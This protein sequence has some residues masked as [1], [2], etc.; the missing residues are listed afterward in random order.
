MSLK[1]KVVHSQDIQS[2]MSLRGYIY[3]YYI[4]IYIYI[5]ICTP[6]SIPKMKKVS[7]R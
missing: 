5:Y 1:G 4:Y 7:P 2:I 3:I 6:I